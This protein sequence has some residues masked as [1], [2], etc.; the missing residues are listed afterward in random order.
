MDKR[1]EGRMELGGNGM[2]WRHGESMG[3]LQMKATSEKLEA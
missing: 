2:D 1:K 3:Y